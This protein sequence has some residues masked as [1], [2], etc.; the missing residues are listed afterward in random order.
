MKRGCEEHHPPPPSGGGAANGPRTNGPNARLTCPVPPHPVPCPPHPP[1]VPRCWSRPAAEGA[2]LRR[3]A[4]ACEAARHRYMAAAER[5][6]SS[7]RC[8]STG[9][10]TGTAPPRPAP[11][12][13]GAAS[14]APQ[15]AA[16]RQGRWGRAAGGFLPLAALG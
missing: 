11:Q 15:P 6:A 16:R 2:R 9:T 14:P 4:S 7:G 1:S 5:G 13:G 12:A 3:A 8:G 10:G